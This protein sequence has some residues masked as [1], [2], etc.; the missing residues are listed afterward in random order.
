MKKLLLLLAVFVMTVI[1]VIAEGF[2]YDPHSKMRISANETSPT[3]VSVAQDSTGITVSYS[4]G[5]LYCKEAE[6][7]TGCFS[8]SLDGFGYNDR[9]GYPDIPFRV[10]QFIIPDSLEIERIYFIE[11][12]SVTLPMKISAVPLSQP[13]MSAIPEAVKEAWIDTAINPDSIVNV[14]LTARSGD[15]L[16]VEISVSPLQYDS[17]KQVVEIF[18]TFKY[19]IDFAEPEEVKYKTTRMS[20]PESNIKDRTIFNEKYLIISTPQMK[21]AI[22]QLVKWKKE[23]G[24]IVEEIYKADW[25][26]QSVMNAVDSVYQRTKSLKYL[27]IVGDNTIVPGTPRSFDG[28]VSPWPP[29]EYVTDF[30]Y[31]CLD[32]DSIPDIYVGRIPANNLEQAKNAL[33]KICKTE[34]VPPQSGS[35]YSSSIHTGIFTV[36][37]ENPNQTYEPFVYTCELLRDYATDHGINCIRNYSALSTVNPLNWSGRY[38]NGMQI[39]SEL[40]R[41]NFAW[42]GKTSNINAA[43]NKG[44]LYVLNC[45]HGMKDYWESSAFYPTNYD[46]KEVIS[47]SNS[48]LPIFFNMSCWTGYYGNVKGS[49]Y[50][51]DSTMSLTQA[52]LCGDSNTGAVAVFAASEMSSMG[53]TD[54]MA[55]GF[56]NGL[57]PEPGC[58]FVV[59]CDYGGSFTTPPND[60]KIP[61]LGRLLEKGRN[62][63]AAHFGRYAAGARHNERVFHLFGDPSMIVHTE[64]PTKF[65]DVEV[66]VIHEN[67]GSDGKNNV[68]TAD[69]YV[70]LPTSEVDLNTVIALTDGNGNQ[71]A[72]R[73][74][75]GYMKEA[76]LPV[77]LTITGH[78]K[79]PYH[80]VCQKF[81]ADHTTQ[82]LTI[83]S[84]SPNPANEYTTVSIKRPEI[85]YENMSE[86]RQVAIGVYSVASGSYVRYLK[87]PG[88][89]ESVE[90]K[91]DDLVKGNYIVTLSGDGQILDAK[92]LV[93]IS[94]S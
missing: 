29:S 73:G 21:P 81:L 53:K 35:F 48:L 58:N 94:K 75:I 72:F 91:C 79:I 30:P 59:D 11:R 76:I 64:S 19:R 24:Y 78:N 12:E 60:H 34:Q 43:I 39:P 52:L 70:G 36:K 31:S 67:N 82:K 13:A 63:Q 61:T 57:W 46:V 71:R 42:D 1:S 33:S 27:L 18:K 80:Y 23:S 4:L 87:F 28:W 6:G 85:H 51:T 92:K 90:L 2:H 16:R 26:H 41:P 49:S 8:I 77:T 65:E 89:I 32:G 7:L 15:R 54:A 86:Y 45:G 38:G 9:E 93:V 66:A 44:V 69:I 22:A 37:N 5:S 83:K 3:S 88:D 68:S 10:D 14:H 17:H 50:D 25:N 62:F 40:Q 47:L 56:I 55:I 74:N 84:I 20:P